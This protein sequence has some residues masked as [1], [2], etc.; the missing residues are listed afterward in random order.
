VSLLDSRSLFFAR[1]DRLGDDQYEG[2][3]PKHFL[4]SM[5]AQSIAFFKNAKQL[6]FANCW[7][8]G[9]HE[10]HG[11]WKAYT[12]NEPGV[13][14]RT[15]FDRLK[16]CFQS[17][18]FN[19]FIGAVEYVDYA[20]DNF[21][22]N[23]QSHGV[24]LFQPYLHKRKQFEHEREI[25]AILFPHDPNG[26]EFPVGIEQ[27]GISMPVDLGILLE[28]VR[29]ASTTARWFFDLVRSVSQKYGVTTDIRISEM[30]GDPYELNS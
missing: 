4:E 11:M 15:S 26:S 16:Q 19:V 2:A 7:H 18:A 17:S 6:V 1:A 21:L 14:V 8:Q 28:E 24:D 10:H 27:D 9:Q 29:V 30:A 3:L 12:Q 23:V 20:H 5:N 13:V 22:S 25:R